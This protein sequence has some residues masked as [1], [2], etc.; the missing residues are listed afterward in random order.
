MSVDK[1]VA[2]GAASGSVT[3]STAFC[4][5]RLLDR[6]MVAALAASYWIAGTL[7]THSTGGIPSRDSDRLQHDH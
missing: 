6:F 3:T 5:V 1:G 2:M 4:H 7:R